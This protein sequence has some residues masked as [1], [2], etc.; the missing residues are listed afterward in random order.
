MGNQPER[1]LEIAWLAGI[2]NGEGCINVYVQTK[3][4]RAGNYKGQ[5]IPRV[6]IVNTDKE[7]IEKCYEIFRKNDVGAYI[8]RQ[9]RKL[10]MRKDILVLN[11]TGWKRVLHYCELLLPFLV[12]EK[13]KA[14]KIMVN[15]A[16]HRIEIYYNGSR[17]ESSYTYEDAIYYFDLKAIS[18]RILNDHTLKAV[19]KITGIEKIPQLRYGLTANES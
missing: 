11:I 12:G 17:K 13:E 8:Q 18:G 1:L 6:T 4:Q 7:I 5:F 2:M 16:K 15:W 19:C 3:R 9:T 10:K 14:A